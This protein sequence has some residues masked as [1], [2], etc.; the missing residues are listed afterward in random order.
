MARRWRSTPANRV[1]IAWPTL[2]T[3]A[4]RRASPRSRSS[5][6]VTDGRRFTARQ[7]IPTE[8]VS[9]HP[10]VAIAPQG[11]V[12]IAWDEQSNGT[13][14]VVLGRAAIHRS[15]VAGFTR[16]VVHDTRRGDH[17]I[18]AAAHDGFIVAW[19][20]GAAAESAIRV[21]RVRK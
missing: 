16:D 17:P 3:D 15:G 1:H 12:L 20:S 6:P 10:Q 5:T 2:M 21:E 14:Q 9:R 13:R 8:G 11:Q 7:R 18:V 19:T 4:G